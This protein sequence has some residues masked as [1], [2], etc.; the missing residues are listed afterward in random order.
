[1]NLTAFPPGGKAKAH[2]HRGFET[3]IYGLT[4]RMALY[5]G[6]QLEEMSLIEPG[7]FC[8]IPAGIPHVAFNLSETEPATAIS[9]R[10]DP[11]EQENVILVPELDGLRDADA[12]ALRAA[13]PPEPQHGESRMSQSDLAVAITPQASITERMRDEIELTPDL[14]ASFTRSP[15]CEADRARAPD[16]PCRRHLP[17]GRG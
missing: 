5:H 7:S 11:A 2:Y 17:D 10:N 1:M 12:A 9:A 15:A 8:F 6:P 4:G 3:A 16:Q 14:M 13:R